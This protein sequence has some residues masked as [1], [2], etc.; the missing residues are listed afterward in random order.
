M[1]TLGGAFAAQLEAAGGCQA[2]VELKDERVEVCAPLRRP[3]QLPKSCR[4]EPRL[5]L[6]GAPDAVRQATVLLW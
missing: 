6:P 4:S 1:R 3:V 5:P 2:L